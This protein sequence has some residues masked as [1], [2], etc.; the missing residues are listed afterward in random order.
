MLVRIGSVSAERLGQGDVGGAIP[1]V[2]CA[3]WLLGLAVK[4]NPLIFGTKWASSH[5]G[6]MVRGRKHY[7]HLLGAHFWQG[8]LFGL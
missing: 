7:C 6:C 8:I 5:P 4:K 1:R 3:W 2:L